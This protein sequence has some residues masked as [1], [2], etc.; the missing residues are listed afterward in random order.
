LERAI[1]SGLD[2]PELHYH[3]GMAYHAS[4]QPERAREHLEKAVAEGVNYPGFE[5]ARNTLANL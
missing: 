2:I 5:E 1:A 4:N 3:L